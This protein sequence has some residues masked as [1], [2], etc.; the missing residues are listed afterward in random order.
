[1]A[2]P[3]CGRHLKPAIARR[4]RTPCPW[5]TCGRRCA[6][7]AGCCKR[8]A[9]AARTQEMLLRSSWRLA[10]SPPQFARSSDG[11]RGAEAEERPVSAG[12]W[13]LSLASDFRAG[14]SGCALQQWSACCL[15]WEVGKLSAETRDCA[16]GQRPASGR[17][18]GGRWSRD[19]QVLSAVGAELSVVCLLSL[20]GWVSGHWR[21]L[22]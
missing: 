4:V 3:Q 12:E 22:T 2:S 19:R 10:S 9:G 18:R 16:V 8:P 6:G 15:V 14:T 13:E 21:L 1:M 17:T 20:S 5:L 11:I 7:S